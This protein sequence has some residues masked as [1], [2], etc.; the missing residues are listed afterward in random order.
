MIESSRVEDLEVKAKLFIDSPN[1]E[2]LKYLGVGTQSL[3][4]GHDVGIREKARS[5]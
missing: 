5:W 3:V 4:E 1:C 2:V